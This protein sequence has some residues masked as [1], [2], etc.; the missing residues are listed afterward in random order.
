MISRKQFQINSSLKCVAYPGGINLILMKRLT[1]VP[2][3]LSK[4]TQNYNQ[5]NNL[6]TIKKLKPKILDAKLS[7]G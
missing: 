6:I 4:L 7:I 1:L 3:S 2:S 5:K